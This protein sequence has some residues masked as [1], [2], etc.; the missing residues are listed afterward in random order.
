MLH[1]ILPAVLFAIAA[2]GVPVTRA[3]DE[4]PPKD[5][6]A[7]T[8]DGVKI[9]CRFYTAQAEGNG[10]VVVLLHEYG[11]DPKKGDYDGLARMIALKGFHVLRFDWRGHGGSTSIIPD[12]FWKEQ[13]NQ[14]MVTGYSITNPKDKIDLKDF[15]AGYI[16]T[17][18]NDLA[19]VRLLLDLKNDDK[20]VNTRSIYF[21][22][23]GNSAPILHL[24][25][26]TEWSR[27][28]IKPL[29]IG[30]VGTTQDI[31]T[32]NSRRQNSTDVAGI[33]YAGIVFISPSRNYSYY[34]GKNP[35]KSRVDDQSL[36]DWVTTFSRDNQAGGDMR[37]TTSMLYI[38]GDKD[39]ENPVETTYFADKLVNIAGNKGMKIDPIKNS[40]IFVVKGAKEKGA[41]LLG[42]NNA[43][44]VEDEILKFLTTVETDRKRLN[45][46]DRKYDK[47]MRINWSSFRVNN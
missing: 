32:A 14:N 45:P 43:Y 1:R 17:L 6:S 23:V 47:P 34:Q 38:C 29:P 9:S 28:S 2:A 8:V 12:K 42:K 33:D 10:S 20:S 27:P 40:K 25:L 39:G 22:A 4:K 41:D 24:F 44:R 30:L 7:E 11:A 46:I 26:A 18:A 37:R 13:R 3:Q 15:R 35:V 36:R 19:G 31:V 5:E 16:Y 21:V